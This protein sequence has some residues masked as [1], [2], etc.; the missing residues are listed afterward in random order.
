MRT[1]QLDPGHTAVLVFDMLEAYRPA[2]EQA[3][4]VPPVQRLLA[5]VRAVGVPVCWARADHRTDGADFAR[6]LTDTDQQLRP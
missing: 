5:G 6:T 4:T 2:I 1:L 3:G